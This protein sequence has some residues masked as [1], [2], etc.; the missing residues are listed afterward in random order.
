MRWRPRTRRPGDPL[1]NPRN[2]A[3][4]VLVVLVIALVIAAILV[5]G[6][7]LDRFGG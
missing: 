5:F 6:T 1:V 3:F 4:L 7:F 2:V